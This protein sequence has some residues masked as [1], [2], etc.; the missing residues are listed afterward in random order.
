MEVVIKT[1]LRGSK[2]ENI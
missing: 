2:I 1:T